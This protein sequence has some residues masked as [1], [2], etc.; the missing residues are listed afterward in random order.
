MSRVRRPVVGRH[1]DA[2][3]VTGPIDMTGL[4]GKRHNL[5]LLAIAAVVL[6]GAAVIAVLLLAT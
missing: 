5:T 2:V 6:L 3:D 1:S 4:D